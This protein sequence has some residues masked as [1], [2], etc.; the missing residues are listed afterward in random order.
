MKR[1]PDIK[2]DRI[3]KSDAS[4]ALVEENK[5]ESFLQG[6]LHETGAK[7]TLYNV[8]LLSSDVVLTHSLNYN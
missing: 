8:L 6:S 1:I 5:T 7:M 2:I 4:Y 3:P